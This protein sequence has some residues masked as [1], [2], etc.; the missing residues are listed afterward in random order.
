MDEI[1]AQLKQHIQGEV[2]TDDAVL[3]SKKKDASIYEMK[4]QVVVFPKDA[5]DM[6]E[7]V[8]II[9][10]NKATHP[11][12]SITAR[13]AGT[14]MAGGPLTDSVLLDM[15]DMNHIL[16]LSETS[17]TIEPGVYYRDFE[18]E[19]DKKGVLYPSY[20]A[21]KN[22]C[23]WG[24]IINNNSG[25]E[26]SLQYGQT[27]D[28]VEEVKVVLRDGK[29]HTFHKISKEE[30]FEKMREESLEGELYKKLY[31]LVDNNYDLIQRS[32][33]HV[34]K[35]STG[36]KLW[37][38]WD[39]EN[40]DMGKIFV[41]AQGTF[42][43]VTQATVR[44]VKE[45]PKE[46]MLILFL[47]DFENIPQMVN[48]VLKYGPASFESFD[49]YTFKLAL[50]FFTAFAKLLGSN[51]LKIPFQ[52]LPE[53]WLVA[54]NGM[55]KLVV[56]IEFNEDDQAVIDQKIT[57]LAKELKVFKNMYLR[58]AKSQW[59]IEKY[60][61]IRRES[62]NLLR[63]RVHNKKAA[64]FIDDIIVNPES[65]PE[66]LPKLYSILNTHKLVYTVAGHI[67]NGNFHIIPLM[68]LRKEEERAKIFPIADEVY[69]LVLEYKG[70]LSAEHNDGL[71]RS[72]YLPEQYGKQMY[73]LFCQTKEIF[74]PQGIFNPHKKVGVTKEFAIA[75]MSTT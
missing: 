45:K 9:A 8:R 22:L 50:K 7:A 37:S 24:G 31:T 41:G 55:P 54:K 71:T 23:A 48:M 66:F 57:D 38:V 64:P 52:F 11:D 62:F 5:K 2:S 44:M 43:M 19:A 36:Y 53:F 34:T 16:S 30:L 75:H 32:K 47:K 15:R 70:S 26:R 28:F 21:S 63:Q 68:D 10:E 60:F 3:E 61:A 59:E 42:G 73:D 49:N 29:E 39:K 18:I 4:P 1:I 25:G 20:P 65:L 40:F 13:A 58:K 17:A 69:K 35:N 74:D 33:P 67:G 51:F 72:P 6:E 27:V 46:G 14:D 56:L 12:I